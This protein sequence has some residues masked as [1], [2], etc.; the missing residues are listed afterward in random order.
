MGSF[1]ND[2]YSSF[3]SIIQLY[4]IFVLIGYFFVGCVFAFACRTILKNKGY[5][6]DICVHNAI[7]GFFLC[8]IWLIVCICKPD[9]PNR[10]YAEPTGSNFFEASSSDQLFWFL[11]SLGLMLVVIGCALLFETW[12][13]LAMAISGIIVWI[14]QYA[15]SGKQRQ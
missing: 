14:V 7:G 5:P 15:I 1:Y 3:M 10:A 11:F 2:F 4:L 12:W 6:H 9:C 8:A 13:G